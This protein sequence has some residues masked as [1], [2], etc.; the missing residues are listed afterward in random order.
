MRIARILA[1]VATATISAARTP[2]S[3]LSSVTAGG[4]TKV[5]PEEQ[6][7]FLGLSATA[8]GEEVIMIRKRDGSLQALDGD[9]VSRP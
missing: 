8:G 7:T 2:S 4:A 6:S 3:I 9:K 5:E 1:V